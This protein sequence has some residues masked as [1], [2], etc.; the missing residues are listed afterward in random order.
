M[1]KHKHY[2]FMGFLNISGEA[3][4]HTI[5]KIWQKWV[6]I[7]HEK[8]KT[9][10]GNGFLKYFGWS[11]N[12]YNSQNMGKVKSHSTGKIWKNTNISQLRAS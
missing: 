5:L 11:K 2:K 6:P 7:I 9:F 4:I 12:P 8:K 3:E 10:H 1:G